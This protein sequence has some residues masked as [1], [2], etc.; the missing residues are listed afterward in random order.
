MASY[1]P[2]VGFHF[3]VSFNLPG[4]TGSDSDSRFQEVSG[5]EAELL[6]QDL[7]EGGENRFT[8]HL[9]LRAKYKNLTLK[10]GMLTNSKLIA[11]FKDALENFNFTPTSVTVKL[12]NEK[13]E[14]I[15]TWVFDNVWPVRWA[16]SDFNAK[17]A[18]L[19]VETIELSYNYFRRQT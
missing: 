6:V 11:W 3:R 16:V 18:Q 7:I 17:E 8:H 5:I 10:R 12:L 4:L 2:P 1:Y 9:P 19:V 13:H 15:S 14:P